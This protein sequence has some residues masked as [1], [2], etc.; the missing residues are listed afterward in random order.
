MLKVSNLIFNF[1]P[2]VSNKIRFFKKYL[3]KNF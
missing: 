3:S 2:G 1:S